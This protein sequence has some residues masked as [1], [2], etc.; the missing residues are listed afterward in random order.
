M[1][2]VPN[3]IKIIYGKHATVVYGVLFT[4]TG[5]S[6]TVVLILLRTS[7]ATEYLYLWGSTGML[8]CI[9][10]VMLFTIF[11]QKKFPPKE[12]QL[13]SEVQ[14]AEEFPIETKQHEM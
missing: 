3:I 13:P 9:S 12:N 7:L 1:M 4:Y 8:S 14:E 10:L 2:L 11:D 6:S 5:F